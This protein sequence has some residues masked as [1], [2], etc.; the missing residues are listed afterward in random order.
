MI[1]SDS[2]GVVAKGVRVNDRVWRDDRLHVQSQTR[3]PGDEVR[4]IVLLSMSCRWS[5]AAFVVFHVVSLVILIFRLPYWASIRQRCKIRWVIDWCRRFS[6]RSE[7]LPA[8]ILFRFVLAAPPREVDQF[9]VK[10]RSLRLTRTTASIRCTLYDYRWHSGD[11]FWLGMTQVH[12]VSI[13][14]RREIELSF[15]YNL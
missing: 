1:I 10:T 15:G 3:N 9:T 4:S 12:G 7:T 5:S 6:I 11:L 8:V 2:A 13:R 14:P